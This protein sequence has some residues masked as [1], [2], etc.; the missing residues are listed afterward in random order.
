MR[1]L[2]N[3]ADE[4]YQKTRQIN[5]K[6]GRK[7]AHFNKVY[8]FSPQ[9]ISDVFYRNNAEIFTYKRG[10]GL[11]LWKPY[12]I[13]KVLLEAND[14]DIVFYSDA[15]AF[16]ISDINDLIESM[17]GKSVWLYGLP[18]IEKQYTKYEAFKVMDCVSDEYM[19][20]NQFSGTF[21]MFKVDDFSRINIPASNPI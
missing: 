5:T 16:F 15:G 4:N 9:N 3:F 12:F 20:T 10:C 1:I 17:H 21:M 11:W 6:T 18:L 2:I 14:G 7:K 19:N 8:E 13:N